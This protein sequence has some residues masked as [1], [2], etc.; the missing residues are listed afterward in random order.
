V[1]ESKSARRI[2]GAQY[3]FPYVSGR[4]LCDSLPKAEPRER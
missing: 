1:F 3:Q 4:E 2:L